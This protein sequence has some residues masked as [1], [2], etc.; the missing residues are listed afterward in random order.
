MKAAGQKVDKVYVY[1]WICERGGFGMKLGKKDPIVLIDNILK[2]FSD[3]FG[4]DI[5]FIEKQVAIE[6][7]GFF[8]VKYRYLPLEYDIILENDRG[9]FSI[10]IYDNE[11]AHTFLY[12]IK[13]YDSETTIENVKNALQILKK[14]LKKNDFCFYITRDGKIYKKENQCYKRIKYLTELM[15]ENDD[16]TKNDKRVKKIRI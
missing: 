4:K 16:G 3:T 13:K 14:V 5:F 15:G 8:E 10:E 2:A 11:G 9:V 7:M 1:C 12:R 6:H